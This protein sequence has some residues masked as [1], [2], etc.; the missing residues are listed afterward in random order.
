[1]PLERLIFI[2]YEDSNQAEILA[3]PYTPGFITENVRT[4]SWF[5][6]VSVCKGGLIR[7]YC[8]VREQRNNGGKEKKRTRRG[9]ET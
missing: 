4:F 3:L 6:R 2:L 7:S 9:K 8:L 1:M 5:S